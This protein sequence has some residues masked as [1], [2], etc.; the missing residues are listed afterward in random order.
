MKKRLIE[1]VRNFQYIWEVYNKFNNDLKRRKHAWK[2][3][4]VKVRHDSIYCIH[5]AT[6]GYPGE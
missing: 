4:A 6:Y 1:A 3:I 5:T 2:Q